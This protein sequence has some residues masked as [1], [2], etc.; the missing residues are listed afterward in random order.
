MVA[1]KN[2]ILLCLLFDILTNNG[3]FFKY[4]EHQVVLLRKD[5]MAVDVRVHLACSF[6]VVSFPGVYRRSA[7][8]IVDYTEVPIPYSTIYSA[9]VTVSNSKYVI[10]STLVW[11]TWEWEPNAV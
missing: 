8:P 9:S 1:R 11:V 3:R 5:V 10:R 7:N 6:T 2:A 4:M